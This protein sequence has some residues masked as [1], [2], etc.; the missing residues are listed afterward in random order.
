MAINASDASDEEGLKL[1]MTSMIDVVFLLLIFF[2]VTLKIPE[3]E[4]MIETRI[5]QAEQQGEVSAPEEDPDDVD[6]EDIKLTLRKEENTDEVKTFVSGQQMRSARQLA[7]RLNM[8]RNLND[9]GRVVIDC[10]DNVPYAS[11]IEAI[12]VVQS[13]ELPMAFGNLD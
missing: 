12:S 7:G 4:A 1:K 5:P 6:F 11:L 2:I 3:R 10:Q 9:E 8:F 13:V